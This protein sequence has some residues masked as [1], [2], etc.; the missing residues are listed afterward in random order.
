MHSLEIKGWK[1]IFYV[2]TIQMKCVWGE[3]ILIQGKIV[4]NSKTVIGDKEGHY[5]MTKRL[6]HQKDITI[7]NVCSTHLNIVT[8]DRI[9]WRNR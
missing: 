2:N 5:L 7:I 8:I 1:K 9:E 4:F 3:A 6:I